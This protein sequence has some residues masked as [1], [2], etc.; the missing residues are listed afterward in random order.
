[1]RIKYLKTSGEPKDLEREVNKFLN[2]LLDSQIVSIV[3]TPATNRHYVHY[4][5]I[6]YTKE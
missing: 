2:T 5:V 1:M 6:T 3:I 4:A